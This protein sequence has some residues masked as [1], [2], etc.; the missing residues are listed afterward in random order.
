MKPPPFRYHACSSLPQAL[1]LLS[2]LD[3]A[4]VLAGG[5]SLMPMLNMRFVF[6][7]HLVDINPIADLAFIRDEPEAMRIGAL[8]RQH[9]LELSDA[10]AQR[11][12]ILREA[13]GHVGHIQTR[14]RGTIGGSLCH[15]DPAAELPAVVTAIGGEIE[16]AGT[17]G[18]RTIPMAEFPAFYMTPA[19]EPDEVVVAIRLPHWAA[20]HGYAFEEFARRHGDFAV[21]SASVLIELAASATVRRIAIVLGGIGTAPVQVVAAE[22]A[23]IGT[24]PTPETIAQ[25]AALCR[26]VEARA[27]PYASAEYRQHLAG[28]LAE[29]A[30]R[31]ALHRAR[32]AGE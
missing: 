24:T 21:V 23:L 4:K 15:L 7:D 8:T 14:N 19:I 11:H 22:Q 30:L 17:H 20:G 5:Q 28:A 26:G 3:N 10:L 12:P 6:P 13:L 32:P 18:R 31:R 27:D 9:A 29:R 1:D 25:A 2:S 16:V